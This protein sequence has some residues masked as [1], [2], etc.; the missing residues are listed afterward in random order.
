MGALLNAHPENAVSA[1]KPTICFIVVPM[2]LVMADQIWF[3]GIWYP[4]AAQ[5]QLDGMSIYKNIANSGVGFGQK[6]WFMMPKVLTRM[7]SL[8]AVEKKV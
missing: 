3:W 5:P 6:K 7:D 1:P 4:V 8:W 2:S